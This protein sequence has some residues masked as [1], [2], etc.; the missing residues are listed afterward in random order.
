MN[1]KVS[2]RKQPCPNHSYPGVCL[3]R[4]RKTSKNLSQND[5]RPGR[6]QNAFRYDYSSLPPRQSDLALLFFRK[7]HSVTS[8]SLIKSMRRPGFK[9]G[10]GHVGFCDGQKWRWGR[11]SPRTSVSPANLH[12]IYFSTIIFIITRS[13]HNRPGVAGR[14]ANSLTIQN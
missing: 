7:C 8:K 2:G 13:W 14:S 3:V 10:S 12:S 11:F 4:L 5:L 9:T 1:W 6:Y